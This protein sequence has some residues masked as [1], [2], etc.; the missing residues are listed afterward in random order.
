MTRH[1]FHVYRHRWSQINKLEKQKAA[2][3]KQEVKKPDTKV[4]SDDEVD[5]EDLDEFL[6][7]RCKKI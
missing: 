1:F 4:V 7:W 6:N 5:E 2:I 3:M